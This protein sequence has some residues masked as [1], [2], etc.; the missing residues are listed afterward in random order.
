[1]IQ[2]L[3]CAPLLM[4]TCYKRF[5]RVIYLKQTERVFMILPA[6]LNNIL[7]WFK[8]SLVKANCFP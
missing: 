6:E 5:K 2:C 7:V 1:M 8:I 3:R 4:T